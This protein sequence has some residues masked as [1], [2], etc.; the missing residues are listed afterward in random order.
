MEYI[1]PFG[2]AFIGWFTSVMFYNSRK[3]KANAEADG[4]ELTAQGALLKQ[5]EEFINTITDEKK[6]LQAEI[7]DEK[8][9]LQTEITEARAE[10]REARKQEASE[11]ERVVTAYKERSDAL[12]ELE[13][14]RGKYKL[15]EWNKCEVTNCAKRKPPRAELPPEDNF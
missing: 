9:R 7:A 13:I 11:R 5:Y 10:A 4:A 2:S 1:I 14:L 3:R 6:Y 8:K 15:A 12:V